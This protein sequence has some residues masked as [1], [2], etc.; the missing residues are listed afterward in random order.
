M[1]INF[2]SGQNFQFP[3]THKTFLRG[4]RVFSKTTIFQGGGG[5]HFS[6]R[7]ISQ[8]QKFYYSLDI[9][10]LTENNFLSRLI[11][12]GKLD[13]SAVYPPKYFR[14][15]YAQCKNTSKESRESTNYVINHTIDCNRH[16]TV[17]NCVIL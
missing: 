15:D 8:S 12:K 1:K 9:I 13:F 4:K 16:C 11:K 14:L 3:K 2:T 7:H 10:L 5:G 17:N 6:R